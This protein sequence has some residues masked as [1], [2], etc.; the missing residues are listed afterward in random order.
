MQLQTTP[1]KRGGPLP[2][3]GRRAGYKAPATIK[4]IDEAR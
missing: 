1:K 3:A 2:G 4:L